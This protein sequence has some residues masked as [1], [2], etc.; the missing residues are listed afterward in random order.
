MAKKKKRKRY[1]PLD[2][3]DAFVNAW[4][5]HSSATVLDRRKETNVF[6]Y[7]VMV[8]AA[9]SLELFLKCLHFVRRRRKKAHG[10]NLFQLFHDLTKADQ[11]RITFHLDRILEIHPLTPRM[12]NSSIL[13]DVDSILIRANGMFENLRYWHENIR[14]GS[15]SSGRATSAGIE[16]LANALLLFLLELHPE[17]EERF[18]RFT[19]GTLPFTRIPLPT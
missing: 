14:P 19:E 2:P 12:I 10:H 5:F 6:A 11:S 3:F 16:P 1:P 9:L 4:G 13:L 7:P 18:R 17:W 8:N 15:D